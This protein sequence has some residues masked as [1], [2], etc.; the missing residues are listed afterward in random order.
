[1]DNENKANIQWFPGHM[2]KARRLMQENLQRADMV[3]ELRDA[4]IPNASKNPLLDEL[5]QNK[6][7]VVILSKKDKAD[8]TTTRRWMN[9]I[10]KEHPV[11]LLDITK[12]SL[13]SPI[14]KVCLEAMKEKHEKQKARGIRP[15]AI[16]AMVVGVPNVGKSTLINRLAKRKAVKTADTPGV[17]RSVSLI[18]VNDQLQLLDTP[19]VLWP[20]FEDINVGYYLAITGAIRDTV[21]PLEDVAYYALDIIKDYYPDRLL[22]RY[23]IEVKDQ[24]SFELLEEIGIVRKDLNEGQWDKTRTVEAFIR[25]I[26]DDKLGPVTWEIF[27]E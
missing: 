7:R 18:A 20:K 15:R 8:E 25:E 19:G 2:A 26:R 13:N 1:M 22:K 21:L 3:I 17:T 23:G 9:E 11:L 5:C 6:P 4:R 27:H 10:S 14:T 16:R 12:D 24:T